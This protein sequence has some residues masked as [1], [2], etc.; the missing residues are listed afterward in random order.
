MIRPPTSGPSAD[1]TPMTAP[2]MANA[3]PRAIGGKSSW[4]N[5][6]TAGK[7]MPPPRPCTTRAMMSCRSFWA[8]PHARL[9]AVNRARPVMNTHLWP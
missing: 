9:A 7:K 5:A 1:E 6:L 8:S 4:M 2:R 3:L